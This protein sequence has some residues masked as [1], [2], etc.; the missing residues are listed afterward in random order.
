MSSSL[1]SP[2][3]SA[4]Y[5]EIAGNLRWSVVTV[6]GNLPFLDRILG[7]SKQVVNITAHADVALGIGLRWA[8][9]TQTNSALSPSSTPMEASTALP[10]NSARQR[11]H[12]RALT[13]A[14]PYATASLPSGP[15][16][17]P[18]SSLPP[19]LRTSPLPSL[20]QL[21]GP[22]AM[23]GT[24][25]QDTPSPTQ[26]Y[27]GRDLLISWLRNLSQFSSS[28]SS[29]GSSNGSSGSDMGNM[30]VI[31]EMG[32]AGSSD[33]VLSVDPNGQVRNDSRLNNSAVTQPPVVA[34]DTS[35]SN[36][37]STLQTSAQDLVYTLCTVALILGVVVVCHVIINALVQRF[38]EG[39]LPEG[40]RFPRVEMS[41]ASKSLCL[42]CASRYRSSQ[43][44]TVR[45][46]AYILVFVAFL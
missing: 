30:Y 18:S 20:M 2:G 42:G 21:P 7:T 29:N 31:G 39:D 4:Q 28:S 1:A 40:L 32:A 38:L 26:N 17:P 13:S 35:G 6:Q 36:I 34:T 11:S 24:A 14:A 12:S 5:R 43:K 45:K 22:Q 25:S 8:N 27:S 23:S 10:P 44:L 9:V 37:V 15:Q 3:V 46:G 16:V 41:L 19:L 33:N